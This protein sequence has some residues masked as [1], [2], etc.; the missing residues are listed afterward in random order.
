MLVA[1]HGRRVEVYTRG[2]AGRWIFDDVT[3]D[4]TAILEA[5]GCERPLAEVYLK[6]F[7]R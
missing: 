7:D 4:G 6:V 3:G 1:Q 5:L 2:S